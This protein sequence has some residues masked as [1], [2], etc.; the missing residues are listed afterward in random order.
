MT[1]IP[2][3]NKANILLVLKSGDIL[4]EKEFHNLATLFQSERQP[5]KFL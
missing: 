4:N 3:L 1:D 5:S 2:R